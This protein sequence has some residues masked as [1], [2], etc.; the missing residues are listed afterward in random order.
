M[1]FDNWDWVLPVMPI[2][3]V[4]YWGVSGLN[5]KESAKELLSMDNETIMKIASAGRQW[6]LDNY[7]PKATTQRLLKLINA[8]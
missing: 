3:K 5:F 4:H 1:D 7:S 6:A 8:L 2:N